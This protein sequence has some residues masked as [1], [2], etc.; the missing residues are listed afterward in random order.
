LR[1]NTGEKKKKKH[2]GKRERKK[3]TRTIGD[4]QGSI[5]QNYCTDGGRRNTSRNT[6][7]D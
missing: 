2:G 5:R 7:K 4:C 1:K 3:R 6:G